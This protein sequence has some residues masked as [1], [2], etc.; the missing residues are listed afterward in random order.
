VPERFNH[1]C[2]L[3]LSPDLLSSSLTPAGLPEPKPPCLFSLK[4]RRFAPKGIKRRAR[5]QKSIAQRRKNQTICCAV[6][7]ETMRNGLMA[8][9]SVMHAGGFSR[10]TKPSGSLL[11]YTQESLAN[12]SGPAQRSSIYASRLLVSNGADE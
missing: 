5:I 4:R 8:C 1:F 2:A 6:E 12:N 11:S 10:A 7:Q 3:L 9:L